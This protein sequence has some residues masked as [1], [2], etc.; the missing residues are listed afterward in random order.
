MN[1]VQF[2]TGVV[3]F[4]GLSLFAAALWLRNLADK[5]RAR[6][7]A[8]DLPAAD[9]VDAFLELQTEL[10]SDSGVL[11]WMRRHGDHEVVS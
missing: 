10:P 5:P 11:R 7:R 9:A 4:L 3:I 6:H 1:I 8:G 2:L